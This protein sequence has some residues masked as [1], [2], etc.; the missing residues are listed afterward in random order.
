MHKPRIGQ[1]RQLL[2][3]MEERQRIYLE[4]ESGQPWPW[5]ADP[6]LQRYKFCCV[7]REQDRVT[8]WIRTNW[9]EPYKDHPNLC[10]AMCMA[11]VI[12]WPPT[13]SK[14]SFP[15]NWKPAGA[16]RTLRY[17]KTIGKV[18]TS[19]YLLGQVRDAADRAEFTVYKLLDPVYRAFNRNP[20][21]F[22]IDQGA[23]A[24]LQQSHEWM[25]QFYGWGKFL[26]YEVITDLRHTKYLCNAPDILT[27]ANIGPGAQRGLNRIYHRPL[28]QH[29]KQEALLEE[30][31]VVM[32]W[33]ANNRDPK[34]LPTLEAR[35][36]EHSL[37]EY[38]KYC[39]VQQ[40]PRAGLEVYRPTE[41]PLI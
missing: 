2:Y 14:L 10:F 33:I 20:P 19:A 25:L 17:C 15:T 22:Y 40:N 9:R 27:W 29:H 16:L 35:D 24:T 28:N 7:Y 21:A 38:D 37:C 4:K 31:G 26:A 5:T 11:R 6:I 12:N 36:I 8:Q 23:S 13:L 18:Y 3:W 34:L 39:R 41:R 30:L 1:L 32:D